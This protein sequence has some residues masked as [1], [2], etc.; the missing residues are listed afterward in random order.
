MNNPWE[1]PRHDNPL[2]HSKP[3]PTPLSESAPLG[4]A[5]GGSEWQAP[6]ATSGGY[7]GPVFSGYKFMWLSVALSLIFGPLGL[8]YVSLL[9][10]L[11]ALMVVSTFV[12]SVAIP[13]AGLMGGG[14][15]L[16]G[17]IGIPIAWCLTVPWAI[18][19]TKRH[20][21]RL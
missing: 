1:A 2:W 20:N 18:I 19:A 12:P 6:A 4:D 10:G 16:A 21:A 9:N 17:T 13:L 3:N 14:R 11:A 15:E 7:A 5:A 8:F